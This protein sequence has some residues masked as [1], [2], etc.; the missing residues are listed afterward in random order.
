MLLKFGKIETWGQKES[1]VHEDDCKNFTKRIYFEVYFSFI[2]FSFCYHNSFCLKLLIDV[3]TIENRDNYRNIILHVC[4]DHNHW[5]LPSK[6][7][8]KSLAPA[9]ENHKKL[10]G[11]LCLPIHLLSGYLLTRSDIA[12]EKWLC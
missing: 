12:Q 6:L 8:R 7:I 2:F 9:I 4:F 10:I 11:C 3:L 5:P 1:S